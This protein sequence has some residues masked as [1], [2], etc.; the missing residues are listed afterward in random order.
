[1]A[2]A[3]VQLAEKRHRLRESLRALPCTARRPRSPE[4]RPAAAA[5]RC[6]GWRRGA[7]SRSVRCRRPRR[8]CA[9]R[10]GGCRARESSNR[11]EGLE[12]EPDG[13][14]GPNRSSALVDVSR[15]D[16]NAA[17]P[18]NAGGRGSVDGHPPAAT[19][20]FPGRSRL[21][22]PVLNRPRS[23]DPPALEA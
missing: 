5:R 11:G 15:P 17:A 16:V 14:G 23:S 21:Y 19:P 22:A 3:A 13:R 12:S 7:A 9:P 8:G 2:D 18:R 4:R 20:C 10:S 1:V 6:V